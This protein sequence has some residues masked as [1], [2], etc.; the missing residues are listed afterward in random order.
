MSRPGLL[1]LLAGLAIPIGLH[2]WMRTRPRRL[3]WPAWRFLPHEEPADKR[4]LHL[5]EPALM[6][7]RLLAIAAFVLA[8][9][10]PE[11]RLPQDAADAAVAAVERPIIVV[12]ASASMGHNHPDSP[13]ARAAAH[14][15][16]W[17]Q[18]QNWVEGGIYACRGKRAELIYAADEPRPQDVGSLILD[19]LWFG[20]AD[21]AAC[22]RQLP[23]D[24]H[25]LLVLSDTP[26]VSIPAG[27]ASSTWVGVGASTPRSNLGFGPVQ[28]RRNDDRLRIDGEILGLQN[29]EID[30]ELRWHTPQRPALSLPTENGR[31][32]V[33]LWAPS[34]P[35]RLSLHVDSDD[36]AVWDNI[37][38]LWTP[39]SA[40]PIA[41]FAGAWPPHVEKRLT[42]VFYALGD[43]IHWQR[44]LPKSTPPRE[45]TWLIYDAE[46]LS[47]ATVRQV[48][49]GVRGGDHA[50]VFAKPLSTDTPHPLIPGWVHPDQPADRPNVRPTATLAQIWPPLKTLQWQPVEVRRL[51]PL[52]DPDAQLDVLLETGGGLPILV[53]KRMGAGN[54]FIWL[55]APSRTFGNLPWTSNWLP[56]WLALTDTLEEDQELVELVTPGAPAAGTR[57]KR[58]ATAANLGA[59]WT[60]WEH[61]QG[62]GDVYRAVRAAPAEV[63]AG[64]FARTVTPKPPAGREHQGNMRASMT[65]TLFLLCLFIWLLQAAWSVIRARRILGL[66]LLAGA[67]LTLPNGANADAL[68]LRPYVPTE[69]EATGSQLDAVRTLA[70]IWNRRASPIVSTEPKLFRWA[71]TAPTQPWVWWLGCRPLDPQR[72][73]LERAL[74]RFVRNHGTLWVD[75][76]GG[77]T[78]LT[79]QANRLARWARRRGFDANWRKL[80]G[81]H[82]LY[83]TFYLLQGW[84]VAREHHPVW[85]LKLDDQERIFLFAELARS[86]TR[87]NNR[88]TRSLSRDDRERMVRQ[89]LNLLMYATTYDYKTDGIH[90]PFILERRRRHR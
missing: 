56:L 29:R 66:L 35:G 68:A 24:A 21:L 70:N 15:E 14:A 88:W 87:N 62:G 38:P 64:T 89:G 90:L 85:A 79:S 59:A 30:V 61:W 55:I 50:I 33:N 67:G 8:A 65:R 75:T 44:E 27:F 45:H 12:D 80:D 26:P 32:Q 6:A 48:E 19:A 34:K 46:S 57:R 36:A 10:G 78:T 25:D 2:L 60:G 39:T 11:R 69:S 47:S 82:V 17:W 3:P 53:R 5:D 23:R 51:Y 37:V 9:A 18:H 7:L 54:L 43:R 42:D 22:L 84:Q 28:I 20:T 58:I 72:L 52:G 73:G 41:T 49:Q 13:L 16:R 83:R 71:E 63:T 4:R 74:S 40:R 86:F 81:E 76:C 1:W 77:G 31:F